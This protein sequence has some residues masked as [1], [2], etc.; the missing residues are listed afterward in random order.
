MRVARTGEVLSADPAINRIANAARADNEL[1]EKG[2]EGK[3]Q[4]NNAFP[5]TGASK[6]CAGPFR[7][8]QIQWSL[9]RD[10]SAGRADC[11][12]TQRYQQNEFVVEG[13]PEDVDA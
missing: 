5:A 7:V 12:I 6:R 4:G 9:G 8:P 3:W 2:R 1:Q 13:M 11:R 10:S